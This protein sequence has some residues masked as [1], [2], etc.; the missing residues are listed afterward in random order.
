MS[1]K[2]PILRQKCTLAEALENYQ[3]A[4]ALA[5]EFGGIELPCPTCKNPTAVEDIGVCD[6]CGA[7]NCP[8]CTVSSEDISVC[9]KCLSSLS[10]PENSAEP[11]HAQ[12]RAGGAR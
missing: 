7:Y 9:E 1:A 10:P 12:L 5:R 6:A 4:R 2:N 3:R 11:G 8:G